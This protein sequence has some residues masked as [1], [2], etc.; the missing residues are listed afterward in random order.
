MIDALVGLLF[1][2]MAAAGVTLILLPLPAQRQAE[3]V[4]TTR[5][6]FEG[7]AIVTHIRVRENYV[8]LWIFGVFLSFGP[9]QIIPHERYDLVWWI[10]TVLALSIEV[11]MI[12]AI[13][14]GRR[15]AHK[16]TQIRPGI[17]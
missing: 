1:F 8:R 13:L 2:G 15:D 11:A 12:G 5:P 4:L 10:G 6:G 14:A 16:A 7:V 17:G 3:K 9:I